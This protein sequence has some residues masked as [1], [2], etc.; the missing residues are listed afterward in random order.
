MPWGSSAVTMRS[1]AEVLRRGPPQ[2]RGETESKTFNRSSTGNRGPSPGLLRGLVPRSYVIAFIGSRG[3]SKE[4]ASLLHKHL[5]PHAKRTTIVCP[6]AR[7]QQ[8]Q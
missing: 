3:K 7:L 2:S 5:F 6:Q 1:R 8:Q 4:S